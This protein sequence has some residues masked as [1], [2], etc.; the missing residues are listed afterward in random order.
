MSQAALLSDRR[1]WPVFWTQFLGAFNDNLFKTALLISI[2]YR[3]QSVFG[4]PSDRVVFIA[5]GLFILPFFLFS[6][7]AGQLSDKFQKNRLMRSVKWLE[8]AAM[9]IA[10]VGLVL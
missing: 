2:K 3:N 9:G 10:A 6:P 1:Y 8:V 4:M 7:L 5:G